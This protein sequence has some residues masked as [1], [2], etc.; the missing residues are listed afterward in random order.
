[1]RTKFWSENTKCRIYAED[2]VVDGK[3]KV[4]GTFAPV[5]FNWAPYHEGI[6]GNGSIAPHILD[7]GTR[8]R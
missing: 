4:N 2:L 6:L 3:I 5:F 1:M 8:W 7:L